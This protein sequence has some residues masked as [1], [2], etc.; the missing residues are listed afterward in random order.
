[1]HPVPPAPHQHRTTTHWPD[2]AQ[3]RD[4]T[5]WPRATGLRTTLLWALLV[6]LLG[7]IA[8]LGPVTGQAAGGMVYTPL[9][10]SF[11]GN[12][13]NGIVLMN[14]A[15]AQNR[16]KDPEIEAQRAQATSGGTAGSA[17]GTTTLLQQFNQTLQRS[18][19][20]RLAVSATN[21]LIGSTGGMQ[22]GEVDTG[23]FLIQI[24]DQGGGLLRVSTTDKS[25][26]EAV[27][28]QIGNR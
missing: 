10:P 7:L 11:G 21:S 8:L 22:P 4:R 25:T 1:M 13:N 19:L 26:G 6:V 3:R 18:I 14:S 16:T 12:P 2:L 20:S 9:N 27:S 28:F 17:G 24:V 23:D 15:Q 5:A